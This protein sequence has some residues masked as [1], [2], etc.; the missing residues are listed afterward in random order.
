ML[1]CRALT[2][3]CLVVGLVLASVGYVQAG[4]KTRH[5]RIQ[6]ALYEMRQARTEL[7]TGAK[8]FGGHRVKALKA[9][10]GAIGEIVAGLE[11]IGENTRGM[12]PPE[13][14][15]RN[16]KT[17]PHIRHAM[18]ALRE[19]RDVLQDATRKFGGHRVAA[20][21]EVETAL[22]ELRLALRFAEQ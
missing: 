18:Q 15:Y 2:G 9:L 1:C 3:A 6:I 4:G 14:P 10:N 21:R 22:E 17:Y 7:E 12:E 8:I 13:G 20:L 11:A 5:P 16:Y 19:A